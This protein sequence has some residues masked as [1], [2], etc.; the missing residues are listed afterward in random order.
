MYIVDQRLAYA[1]ATTRNTGEWGISGLPAG[2]YRLYAQPGDE[3]PQVGRV[4]PDAWSF[5]EGQIIE[6]A[7]DDVVAGLDMDLPIGGELSGSVADDLG[8]PLAGAEVTCVGVDS[9][10]AGLRRSA[11]T[12]AS[13]RYTVRGLDGEAGGSAYSVE[14][15][16]EGWPEQ[17]LGGVYDD[18]EAELYDL[19]PGAAVDAGRYALLPG[20]TVSGAVLGP[21]GPVA[22]ASV[23]GYATSQVVDTTAGEDG[24]YFIS[25]LPPGDVLIWADAPGYGLSYYPDLDRPETYLAAPEEGDALE[26]IELTLPAEAVLRGRVLDESQDLSGVTVLAYNDTYTVGQGAQADAEGRFEIAG[27]HGG[28]YFLYVY[29]EDEGY[30][31]DFA[32]GADG[33]PAPFVV[34]HEG[35]SEEFLIS[36]E[37]AAVL[38]GTV[39]DDSGE[40]V[41][42]A[43]V[44]AFSADDE[45]EAE[46]A[47][48]ER[49]GTYRLDGLLGGDW[50][51]EIF[52]VPYCEG[53]GGFVPLY[54]PG[55]VNPSLAGTIA[56]SAGETYSGLDFTLPVD[57]DL[58]GMADDWEREYGLDVGRDDSQED[59]DGDGFVNLDEYYLGTDPT[60]DSSGGGGGCGGKEGGCGGGQSLLLLPLAALLR[61]RRP[62]S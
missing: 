60:S 43:Y 38:E 16:A 53:D 47:V 32:P 45:G 57:S 7:E 19:G 62:R 35:V 31:N 15:E 25:G 34:P 10:V 12:D 56:L 58:D 39:V 54:W 36:P 49:D 29:A 1:S 27:L 40:P 41:Y 26:G 11:L 61:R 22:E 28:T 21:D 9:R 20:V 2:R 24:E 23:H 17:L 37:P 33:E 51:L 44:Y 48:T 3:A 30:L 18:A 5:C 42:G 6:L 13:G 52:Y 8:Q 59:P 4:Y 55:S 46:A 14:V 50:W